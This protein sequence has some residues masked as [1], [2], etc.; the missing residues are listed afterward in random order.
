MKHLGVEMFLEAV[1]SGPNKLFL[2]HISHCQQCNDI[3]EKMQ[4]KLD[5][6]RDQQAAFSEEEIRLYGDVSHKGFI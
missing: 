4:D 3:W 1:D 2:A 5:A 6:A